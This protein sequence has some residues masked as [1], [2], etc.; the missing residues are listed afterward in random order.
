MAAAVKSLLRAESEGTPADRAAMVERVFNHA[1]AGYLDILSG[2]RRGYL[3]PLSPPGSAQ[4]WI[5][6]KIIE[7]STY[8][9]D[10]TRLLWK[11]RTIER[12]IRDKFVPIVVAL[13]KGEVEIDEAIRHI[14]YSIHP[15][16]KT[17]CKFVEET[18]GSYVD[19]FTYHLMMYG[20]EAA[21]VEKRPLV[22]FCWKEFNRDLTNPE[23]AL[24]GDFDTNS[25]DGSFSKASLWI[26]KSV[27]DYSP[28]KIHVLDVN[29]LRAPITILSDMIYRMNLN[30]AWDVIGRLS[31]RFAQT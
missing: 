2:R 13:E 9:R 20:I 3:R 10:E 14:D 21:W 26:K 4:G 24:D 11:D 1:D 6:Q 30:G 27:R 29:G 19:A 31:G 23:I 16:S 12:G 7:I 5:P 17:Y 15:E 22:Q 28:E 8:F 25:G 18:F